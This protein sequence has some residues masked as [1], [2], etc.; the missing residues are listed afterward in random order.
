MKLNDVPKKPISDGDV[1]VLVRADLG[2]ERA[3]GYR[4]VSRDKLGGRGDTFGSF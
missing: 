2:G 4:I 1:V 3:M